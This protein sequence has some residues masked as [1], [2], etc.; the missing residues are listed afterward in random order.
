MTEYLNLKIGEI[1]KEYGVDWVRTDVKDPDST[2]PDNFYY[3]PLECHCDYN[4]NEDS[5]EPIF[6]LGECSFCME[7]IVQIKGDKSIL[8]CNPVMLVEGIILNIQNGVY[9]APTLELLQSCGQL[10]CWL[11]EQWK[12]Y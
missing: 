3:L 6:F 2:Y 8:K 5:D 11:E 4:D 10:H 1:I 9:G 7:E 12:Y